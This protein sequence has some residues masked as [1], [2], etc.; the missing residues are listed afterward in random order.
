MAISVLYIHP[1]GAF[2][3]ASRSLLE[4]IRGFPEY[5]IEPCLITP[6]GTVVDAFSGTNVR[7]FDTA[8]ISQLDHTRYGY[9][10]DKRWLI[11]LRELGYLPFTAGSLIW[12]RLRWPN[13][14]VVHVNELT[15]LP[16][17]LLA[18]LIF[19]VPIVVHVRSVQHKRSGGLRTRLIACT[20]RRYAS[21]VIAIDRTV[22]RSLPPDVQCEIVHNGF[23]P[24][25][26]P[27]DDTRPRFGNPDQVGLPLRVGMV[28]NFLAFKGVQ[29]F[30]EAARLCRDRGLNAE[31]VL[32]GGSTR[33]L[34]KLR[35]WLLSRLGFAVDVESDIRR[36]IAEHRLDGYV[37]LEGFVHDISAVYR[38][39]DLLCFPSLL[40]A[41]GRPVYEAA[42]WK[43]PSIVAIRNPEPDTLVDGVTG[44]CIP[45]GD[46]ERLADAVERFHA[47]P[48]DL[49]RMGEAA[50]VLAKENFDSAKN[51]ERVLN[52]YR[53]LLPARHRQ[54]S[55]Q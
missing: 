46:P 44:L 4:L 2:G 37:R 39:L 28:S 54:S 20:L 1:Y 53:H 27:G 42:F 30:V 47:R 14:D 33:Q 3:G 12:A 11:L 6:R 19:R 22:A 5:S 24:R 50:Q 9:Y 18:K 21:A 32:T 41:V 36:Y 10:R 8:G 35:G 49:R 17:I 15:A 16:A 26:L 43:I 48:A 34:G 38:R 52:I 7:I 45:P 13:P 55:G 25:F 40:D 29:E 23:T 31:F 51:A